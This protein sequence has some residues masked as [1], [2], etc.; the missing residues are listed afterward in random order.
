MQIGDRDN[1]FIDD[2]KLLADKSAACS[3][4]ATSE[5]INNETVQSRKVWIWQRLCDQRREVAAVVALI[6]MAVVWYDSGSS[7][8]GSELVSQDPLD[9]YD[10]VLSDFTPVGES[11]PLRESANPFEPSPNS[12]RDGVSATQPKDSA[13]RGGTQEFNSRASFR[14]TT[15]AT[16]AEYSSNAPAFNPSA[17]GS[18]PADGS[19]QPQR[20]RVRFAGRIQPSN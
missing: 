10:A 15:P 13:A 9:S 20:R 1:Q 17:T 2:S 11:Q 12:V 19:E 4:E 3:Q 14:G 18:V 16:T 8:S 7:K 5:P 6:V